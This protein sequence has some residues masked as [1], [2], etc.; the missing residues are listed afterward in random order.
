MELVIIIRLSIKFVN[1][2]SGTAKGNI[3]ATNKKKLQKTIKNQHFHKHDIVYFLKNNKKS[4]L[5]PF[6][7]LTLWKK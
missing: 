2:T 5:K 3:L 1:S 7:S 4:K 6:V